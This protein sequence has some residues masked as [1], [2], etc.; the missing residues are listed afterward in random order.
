MQRS[1]I[2]T[3]IIYSTTGV[4]SPKTAMHRNVGGF[5]IPFLVAVQV[6]LPGLFLLAKCEASIII[7]EVAYKGSPAHCDGEDWIE[8][9][10]KEDDSSSSEVNLLN[11]VL[12][13]DKGKDDED[14]TFFPNMTMASGEFKVLCGKIDFDFKIGGSDSVTLLDNINNSGAVLSTVS[15]PGTGGDTET[16][17]Y[18]DDDSSEN[19]G[20]YKYTQTPTPGAAN[21]YTEPK[22]FEQQNREQN[23]AGK[24]FFLNDMQPG[25]TSDTF[26]KIVDIHVMMDADSLALIHDHPTFSD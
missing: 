24:D 14:A 19:T 26:D 9:L 5:L 4:Q 20:Y 25:G 3:F 21:I 18:F 8:L 16:Y 15:L 6:I 2:L 13:D 1:V 22:S 11:F 10:N 17:A 7:N 12:H 23:E